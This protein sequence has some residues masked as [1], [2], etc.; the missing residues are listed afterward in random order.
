LTELIERPVRTAISFV[1]FP[2]RAFKATIEARVAVSGFEGIVL[3]MLRGNFWKRGSLKPP[4]E[5]LADKVGH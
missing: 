3:L 5:M 1:V 4:F 2:D